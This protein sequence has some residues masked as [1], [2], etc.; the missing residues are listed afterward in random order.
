M[1]TISLLLIIT[2]L[3]SFS[4]A[5]EITGG[6]PTTTVSVASPSMPDLKPVGSPEQIVHL[7]LKWDEVSRDFD[8]ELTNKAEH[9]ETIL[10]VQTPTPNLFV[11]KIP[12]AIPAGGTA[13]IALSYVAVLGQY[14]GSMD[15]VRVRTS[16]GLRAIR[17]QHDREAV[18]NFSKPALTWV[19][20]DSALTQTVEFTV[21]AGRVQPKAVRIFGPRGFEPKAVLRNVAPDR[22]AIDITPAPTTVPLRFDVGIDCE[23]PI[24]GAMPFPCMVLPA[25]PAAPDSASPLPRP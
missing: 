3:C 25:A 16:A 11:V 13:K 14:R 17:V 1:K 2:G 8:V 12:E 7:G 21:V 18:F 24:P 23:H 9:A 4:F 10:G 15:L 5:A 19:V 20:G 22:Y 6:S